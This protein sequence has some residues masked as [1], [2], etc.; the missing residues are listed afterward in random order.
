MR[1]KYHLYELT[2][3]VGLARG[4]HGVQFL[5]YLPEELSTVLHVLYSP[6]LVVNVGRAQSLG[7]R[8][9]KSVLL[10]PNR[11]LQLHRITQEVCAIDHV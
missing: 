9:F 8:L 4:N 3:E 1:R 10:I 5:L 2:V 11:G 7:L 6:K